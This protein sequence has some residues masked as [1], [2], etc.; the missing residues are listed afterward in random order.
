MGAG[1]RAERVSRR[2][3]EVLEFVARYG[4]VPRDAVAAWAGTAQ[5]MTYRRERRL[6]IAGLVKVERP[7]EGA[8]SFLSAT[9]AGI[10]VCGRYELPLARVSPSKLQHA[11][12]CAQLGARLER[13]GLPLLSEF[14]LR[15]EERAWGRRIYSIRLRERWH[16][17]DLIVVGELPT[18]IEVELSRK[19]QGRLEEIIRLW[20]RAVDE[21]RFHIVHYYCATEVLPYVQRAVD[22]ARAEEQIR[23]ELLRPAASSL[24]TGAPERRGEVRTAWT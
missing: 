12:A 3:V 24:P 2:D 4:V 13:E 1:E 15:A 5:S 22:R 8:G 17:P 16:R 10:G 21:G 6:R 20:R 9:R 23:I 7:L 11:S 19:G 14:E 18:A